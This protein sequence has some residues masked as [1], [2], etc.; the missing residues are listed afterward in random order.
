MFSLRDSSREGK[1]KGSDEKG[2]L[3]NGNVVNRKD[4]YIYQPSFQQSHYSSYT[5]YLIGR[6]LSNDVAKHCFVDI[7]NNCKMVVFSGLKD[8]IRSVRVVPVVR[9]I[10][11]SEQLDLFIGRATGKNKKQPLYYIDVCVDA[12]LWNWKETWSVSELHEKL[13]ALIPEGLELEHYK[14][15]IFSPSLAFAYAISFPIFD[16]ETVIVD[17]ILQCQSLV[18]QLVADAVNALLEEA[19]QQSVIVLF[20]FPEEVKVICSQYLLYFVQFLKDVGIEATAEL[21][22]EAGRTLFS[23][24]PKDKDEAL[25]NI[26]DALDI[27]LRLPT[28]PHVSPTAV[29]NSDVPVQLL[30]ANIQHLQTQLMMHSAIIQQK[31]ALIDQQRELIGLLSNGKIIVEAVGKGNEGLEEDRESVIGDVIKVKPYDIGGFAELDLPTLVRR[32]KEMFGKRKM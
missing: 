22:E 14:D 24:T 15:G 1:K 7:P 26:R 13:K 3:Y 23:V 11:P 29:I 28:A 30:A 8:K 17:S 4:G 18:F 20:D 27:Y 9:C 31:D 12:P 16:K 6:D 5:V 2:L 10:N 19:R 21:K 32:L 25:D